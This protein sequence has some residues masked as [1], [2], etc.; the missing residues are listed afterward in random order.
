MSEILH[1]RTANY[2]IWKTFSL[3]IQVLLKDRRIEHILLTGIKNGYT[4]DWLYSVKKDRTQ[5]KKDLRYV[6]LPI[7][8]NPKSQSQARFQT[9]CDNSECP[10]TIENSFTSHK[11]FYLDYIGIVLG[12]MKSQANGNTCIG[13]TKQNLRTRVNGHAWEAAF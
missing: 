7:Y 12:C 8:P 5:S 4:L 13:M 11:G 2:N 3:L 1:S 9:I 10:K 6:K